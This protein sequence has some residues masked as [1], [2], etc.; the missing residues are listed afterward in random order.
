MPRL[1]PAALLS[2]AALSPAQIASP[3]R[4]TLSRQRNASVVMGEVTGI[5]PAESAD[6]RAAAPGPPSEPADGP[7]RARATADAAMGAWVACMVGSGSVWSMARLWPSHLAP[8]SPNLTA[9]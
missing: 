2:A 8:C 3:I 1:F 4:H 7:D 6:G 9:T 5:D